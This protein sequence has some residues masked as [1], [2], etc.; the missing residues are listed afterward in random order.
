[1]FSKSILFILKYFEI[2]GFITEYRINSSKEKKQ[3]SRISTLVHS[4]I[5]IYFICI[6]YYLFSHVFFE[7]KILM[8]TNELLKHLNSV[9]CYWVT[10]IEIYINRGRQHRFWK[11]FQEIDEKYCQHNR[12]SMFSYSLK[13]FEYF[14]ILSA[15]QMCI[16]KNFIHVN[17][18][19]TIFS[20]TYFF[21][22]QICVCRSFYYLFFVHLIT[23]ELH[24]IHNEVLAMVKKSK[25]FQSWK[26]S[27][28]HVCFEISRLKWL[29]EYYC[30]VHEMSECI[31]LVNGWSQFATI[32]YMF[33]ILVCDLIWAIYNYETLPDFFLYCEHFFFKYAHI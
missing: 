13:F 11:M 10:V 15:V 2:V 32:T 25:E 27:N 16:T 14:F 31:N 18:I 12:T 4:A 19:V 17:T 7:L 5:A 29:R 6:V 21:L 20:I 33:N 26:I 22:A 3:F 8:L 1:M 30:L 9:A 23:H 28:R 24:I